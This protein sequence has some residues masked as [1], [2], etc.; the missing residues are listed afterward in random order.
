[1]PHLLDR[2]EPEPPVFGTPNIVE[3]NSIQDLSALVGF[4]VTEEFSLPFE[5]EER[6]YCSYWNELAEITYSGKGHSA[7]FR[8][9]LGTDDCSGDYNTYHDIT[10]IIVSGL[11]I[12]LKGNDGIYVL[13]IWTDGIYAYSLS[14]SP[15]AEK[16]VWQNSLNR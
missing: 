13:A 9:S 15:G 10:E 8:Q 6:T 4:E 1:M 12:T 2:T 5:V 14:L 16:N 3:A 11:N 7:V